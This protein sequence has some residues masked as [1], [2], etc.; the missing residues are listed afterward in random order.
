MRTD[1]PL[2]ATVVVPTYN[3]ADLLAATLTS[4]VGQDLAADRFEVVV[5][6]DG[7]TDGTP[8]VVADFA[9]RLRMRY[10]YQEDDGYRVAAA[11]NAGITAAAGDICV[12]V[13]CGVVLTSG[14]VRAHLEA[15]ERTDGPAAVIGYVH[16][17]EQDDDDAERLRAETDLADLDA[18]LADFVARGVWPDMRER[19]Y[20]RYDDALAGLPAPWV[21]YWTCNVSASTEQLRRVGMF[22]EAFRTWGGE[23][24]DLAYRL[25]QDGATFALARAATALHL[26]HPKSY[27]EREE[28]AIANYRY[29]AGKYRDPIV[30]LITELPPLDFRELNDEVV[31]RGLAVATT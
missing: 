5:C 28:G 4:L 14:A 2:T 1:H 9:T 16:G 20:A 23:D 21:L 13:D 25:F 29:M 8:D 24:I 11:R 10:L 15:H 27:A 31:E 17:F 26:P 7:S 18:T 12:F 22:D 30:D 19:S 3:R 6:D